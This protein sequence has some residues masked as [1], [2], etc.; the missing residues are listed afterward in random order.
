MAESF[1][2]LPFLRCDPYVVWDKQV[3]LS[4]DNLHWLVGHALGKAT[5]TGDYGGLFFLGLFDVLFSLTGQAG[6]CPPVDGISTL[7]VVDEQCHGQH[8]HCLQDH[9]RHQEPAHV[10]CYGGSQ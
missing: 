8:E 4:D 1:Q 10:F 7:D 5:G 6:G 9:H 3:V 2:H